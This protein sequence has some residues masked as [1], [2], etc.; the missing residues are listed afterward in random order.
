MSSERLEELLNGTHFDVAAL[1]QLLDTRYEPYGWYQQDIIRSSGK[2][3][4]RGS[5]YLHEGS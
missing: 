3:I 4:Q 5:K 1:Q 2:Q